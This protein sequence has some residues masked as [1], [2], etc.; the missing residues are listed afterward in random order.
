VIGAGA[1]G[2][3]TALNL[4]RAGAR[5]TLVETR[6]AGN[7]LSSSGGESRVIRH[8]YQKRIYVE[9]AQRSLQLW[10]QADG[11]WGQGLLHRKGVLLLSQKN[12]FPDLA[13][14]HMR[15]L[16]VA[17]EAL[18]P[19]ALRKRYPHIMT[20]DIEQALFE[21]DA[22]YIDARRACLAVRDAFVNEGGAYLQGTAVPGAIRNGEMEHLV[23]ED[24]TRL[25][26]E[27]WVFACGPWLKRL[28][29]VDL[30]SRL[31]ISRQ[32]VYFFRPP[33]E[34]V[35]VVRQL[36][37][38][39]DLGEAFW[40]GIPGPDGLFKI[41]DDSRGPEVDPETQ[42]REPGV[43]GIAAARDHMEMRFPVLKGA[44]YVDAR[45]CQYALT[46]DEGFILARHPGAANAWLVGGGSGHGFKH[47][48]ALGEITAA[49]V[50]GHRPP[51]TVFALER[52]GTVG[53]PPQDQGQ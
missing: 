49:A 17:F 33:A 11:Q 39:A 29:P 6:S 43:D 46:P 1:F 19:A 16:G 3:W 15:A 42:S 37:V 30:G 21:P 45:V 26:A 48:P 51:P 35:E 41:A 7:P 28:F 52:F 10:K 50:L 18:D 22:G 14:E 20:E 23:L 36:P 9:L 38:W 13:A 5:V 34:W 4:L 32:E 27:Q 44:D 24:G 53:Q 2:G 31:T 40:Y 12:D 8:F 25:G 47:G